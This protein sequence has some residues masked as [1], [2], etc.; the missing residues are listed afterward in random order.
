MFLWKSEGRYQ[1]TKS[2]LWASS[3]GCILSVENQKGVNAVQW[4]S[5]DN[6]KGAITVQSI[7]GPTIKGCILSV[8][9][10]KGVNAFQ[11]CSFENQ[12]GTITV[13]NLFCEL[14]AKD[15]YC[16]SVEMQKGVNAVQCS[17]ENQ[18]GVPL[19]KVYVWR[20]RPSGSYPVIFLCDKLF[21]SN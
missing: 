14:A 17:F 2:I 9:S 18:K 21:Y 1:C 16:Q 8:E 5:F 15:A 6:Q 19:F 10:Q 11:W 7:F 3:K 4:C 20:Y 12:K 13:Q